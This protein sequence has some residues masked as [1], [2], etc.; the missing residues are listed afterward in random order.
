MCIVHTLTS[1][2]GSAVQ[3]MC[4]ACD[5]WE[6]CTYVSQ[7][8]PPVHQLNVWWVLVY[9]VCLCVAAVSDVVSGC[10]PPVDD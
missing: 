3:L 8:L 4:I 10:S 9:T 1:A 2:L 6:L 7:M 5:C